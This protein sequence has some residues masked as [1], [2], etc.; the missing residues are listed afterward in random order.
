MQIKISN[1]VYDVVITKKLNAKNTYLRVKKDL[2][3]Y[4]ST[5]TFVSD[6]QIK[7]TIEENMDSIIKMYEKQLYKK[8]L[9]NEFSYLGTVYDQ[10]MMNGE[11]ISLGE[12]RVFIGKDANLDKWYK[13]KAKDIF[14]ERLDY[15]YQNFSKKIPYP[16]LTIRK[17]TSRW[18]V[19]N[20]KL[21]RVTL[22]LELIKKDISCL[23]YVIV[24]EL[25]HFIEMNH[26]NRFWKVVEENYPNY[27]EVRKIM[28]NY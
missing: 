22:N 15:W 6:R 4:V 26:S 1:Q 9:D 18:G 3:L 21:N 5:N 23:D 19:C 20:S 25:S 13:N 14:Q 7:N 17:M 12:A 2:K 28:K 8:N 24:H 11:E 27:R 10:V 16:T